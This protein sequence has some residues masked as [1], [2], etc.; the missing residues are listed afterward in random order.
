MARMYPNRVRIDTKSAAERRLYDEL[1]RQLPDAYTVFHSVAWTLRDADRGARDGEADFLIVHPDKGLLLIEV[2]GGQI[3]ISGETGEWFSNE[4]AIKNPFEQA[5]SNKYSL[6]SKLKESNFWHERHI[7]IGHAVA[8][9]DVDVRGSLGLD[10][11]AAIT[12]GRANLAEL[13][14]WLE[15]AFGYWAAGQRT[16][17]IGPAA[18]RSLVD[19]LSPSWELQTPLSAQLA[20][21]A[22]AIIRLTEE[23]F[24]LLDNLMGRRRVAVRGCAGSGKTTIAIEQCRRLSAQGFRVLLVC[25]NKNLAELL[26]SDEEVAAVVDIFHFH[27]LCSHLAR[28]AGIRVQ[29][30]SAQ[31]SESFF[32]ETLPGALLDAVDRL[33]AQYDAVVVDEGQDFRESWWLPLQCL[34]KD[35]DQGVFYVFYD[36]NQNLYKTPPG[37]LRELETYALSVNCRNT[38][39]IHNAFVTFYR[40]PRTPKAR[41]PEGRAPETYTYAN[42]Q[43]LRRIVGSVL[44][45]LFVVEKVPT[46]QVVILTQRSAAHSLLWRRPTVGNWQLTE[47]WPPASGEVFATTVH[48]FKGLEAPVVILCELSASSGQ[49]LQTLL[50]VACSRARNHLVIVASEDLPEELRLWLPMASPG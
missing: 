34:L 6:L 23:Q 13:G 43:E 16:E 49:D 11:P 42:E 33:G 15:G 37:I 7:P 38:Q 4:F 12:M 1:A 17:S 48:Q 5:K 35:Q 27:G 45:R 10:A 44:Q 36:D 28:K 22:K 21:E 8:L 30:F 9:P 3:R 20:E 41:G 26:K 24:D 29:P 19:L 47:Q 2:K 31:A 32:A 14:K 50:Y 40:G 18:V 46:D 25:F 39:K